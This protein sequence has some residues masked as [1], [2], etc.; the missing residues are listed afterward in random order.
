[1]RQGGEE[2]EMRDGRG[3][4]RNELLSFFLFLSLFG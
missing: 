3:G 4:R 2:E 1:M